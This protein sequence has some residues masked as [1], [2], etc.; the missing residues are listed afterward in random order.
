[1]YNQP[2]FGFG[3]LRRMT[4]E[5]EFGGI[6]HP[7]I[8]ASIHAFLECKLVAGLRDKLGSSPSSTRNL[9]MAGG[10]ALNIKWNSAVRDSGMFDQVW[11][12]PFP[13]DSGSAIGTACCAM[14]TKSQHRS[15]AW[16]V[17][18]GP[19]LK[20]T[21]SVP[22]GWTAEELPLDG[23]AHILHTT[24]MPVVFLTGRAELGPRALGHRSI[25]ACATDPRMKDKLNA[26]KGRENYR[27]VAPICLEHRAPEIFDP[28]SPDPFMLFDHYVRPRWISRVPA[29]CHLDNTARLQTVNHR[30]DPTLFTL[31]ERYEALS[32]IP[33]LCNTSANFKGCGF[34]PDAGSAMRWGEVP[35]I[36]ADGTL[37]T[38]RE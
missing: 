2:D 11:I 15:L 14:L 33:V 7:D 31:I 17:F 12:P 26:A 36:W 19:A 24:G 20:P 13:N 3:I 29:I 1:V 23:V 8:L 5:A 10:C 9:C 4:S 34:F 30:Q 25:L 37:Y 6:S 27:P 35:Y 18:S 32:G 28:G 22:D 38:K 21:E 16:D